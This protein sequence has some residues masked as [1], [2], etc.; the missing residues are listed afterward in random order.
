MIKRFLLTLIFLTLFNVNAIAS[1]IE[2]IEI[3]GNKRI[4]NETII[5]FGQ[6][7]KTKKTYLFRCQNE[8]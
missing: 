1:N 4:T 6:I 8:F 5:L 2:S 7:D 3:I